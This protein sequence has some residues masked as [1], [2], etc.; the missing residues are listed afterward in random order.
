MAV[1]KI[2]NDIYLINTLHWE[3]RLFDELIP[4]PEGTTY[5]AYLVFGGE[6]TAL[7]DTTDT[8]KTEEF[9]RDLEYTG[10]TKIDYVISNHAEQDHSGGIPAVLEK[11]KEAKVV[12]NEKCAELLKTHLHIPENRFHIIK[13]GEILNLG[14]KN[15]TF[16]MTPWVHWPETQVTFLIEDR[17]AFT[18]DFFGAH[19]ASSEFITAG[20]PEVY[21]SAKRYYAEIMAPFRNLIPKNIEKVENLKPEIICPSHGP[22]Y[23]KPEFIINAYKEWASDKVKNLALILYVSMH[24]SIEKA[25]R[26]LEQ[27]LID[28]GIN[29]KVMNVTTTDTGEV[30]MYLLDAATLIVATP[31]VL[32]SAHPSMVFYVYLANLLRPKTK[33]LAIVNSYGW[34]GKTIDDL[35]AIF[36]NFKGEIIEPILFKGLP[37]TQAESKLKELANIIFEKHLALGLV[38]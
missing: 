1:K 29:V 2:K 9:L 7:I 11:Y 18:C 32:A 8:L 10:V 22:C 26:I 3:R 20:T 24:H 5:N 21:E 38:G 34:G 31:T 28:K 30:A 14:N 23:D 17:I 15:L 35:K 37:D 6:K 4:L 25:V 16:M 13:E 12:T 19:L 27:S 33:F 36:S